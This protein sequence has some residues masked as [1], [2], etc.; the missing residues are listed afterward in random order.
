M[1][2]IRD[3]LSPSVWL[4][5]TA[6]AFGFGVF[7]AGCWGWSVG[8]GGSA[9]DHDLASSPPLPSCAPHFL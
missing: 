4:F 1:S 8:H 2:L 9:C 6:G 7:V 5:P 3:F